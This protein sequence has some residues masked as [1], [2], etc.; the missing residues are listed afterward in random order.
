MI[1]RKYGLVSIEDVFLILR[2][3]QHSK[4]FIL[5]K[6]I[7]RKNRVND[8]IYFHFASKAREILLIVAIRDLLLKARI[9]TE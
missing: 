9:E 6:I 2:Y 5:Q 8:E 4:K 3:F 1:F 7:T